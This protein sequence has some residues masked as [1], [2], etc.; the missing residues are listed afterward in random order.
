M[1]KWTWLFHNAV[2][3][4]IGEPHVEC[5]TAVGMFCS[6]PKVCSKNCDEASDDEQK[7]KINY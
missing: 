4:R 6:D 3:T 2:N 5:E 1:I 7:S